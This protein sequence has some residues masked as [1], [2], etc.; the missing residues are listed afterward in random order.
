MTGQSNN[1]SDQL[2]GGTARMTTRAMTTIRMATKLTKV[3]Q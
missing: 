1:D 3:G 2:T